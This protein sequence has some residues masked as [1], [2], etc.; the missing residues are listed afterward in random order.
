MKELAF[1]DE[2]EAGNF[3]EAVGSV[4]E[5]GSDGKAIIK[6]SSKFTEAQGFRKKTNFKVIENKKLKD[7]KKYKR[8]QVLLGTLSSLEAHSLPKVIP[9]SA[10]IASTPLNTQVVQPTEVFKPVEISNTA[11]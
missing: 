2:E 1:E 3:T 5:K 10:S 8:I 9:T 7:G 4:I 11:P 6:F